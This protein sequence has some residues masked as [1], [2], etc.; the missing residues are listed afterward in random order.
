MT[1]IVPRQI[2]TAED[3]AAVL[4]RQGRGTVAIA[5]RISGRWTEDTVHLDDIGYVA[6]QLAGE[7][8]VYL[9]QNRF[10]GW[11]RAIACLAQLNALFTDLDYYNLAPGMSHL[12]PEHVLSVA[13][14]QLDESRI[15][16][17]T[18]AISTGRGIALIWMHSAVPRG[19]LG[20]WQA[21]QREIYHALSDL[22]AD[23]R[24]LDAARVLR[25]IGTE[26]SK[27]R[28]LVMPLTDVGHIWDFDALADEILPL[29]RAELGLLRAARARA[30]IGPH[31]R[32]PISLPS[33]F[34]FM[35]LA[36]G[37]LTD[38]QR[39]LQYRF[40]GVLPSGQRDEWMFCAAVN[41]AYLTRANILPREL[42]E[43]AREVAG[44]G[45]GE[46]RA[47]MS[48][49]QRRSEL[50]ALGQRISYRGTDVDP[51]Y[52]LR[53]E[54]IIERLR[55]TEGE[56]RGAKLHHL[57]N[58]DMQRERERNRGERRRRAAGAID[59]QTYEANS[60]SAHLPWEAEGITRRTWERRRKAQNTLTT[61]AVASPSG[62]MVVK[63]HPMEVLEPHDKEMC[64]TAVVGDP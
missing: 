8:D 14:E 54:T 13:L 41:M 58:L 6:H 48:A 28:T 30:W 12:R 32:R 20:R 49:V 26:N 63:P 22:G 51:R 18:I 50:A 29:K 19:A 53:N 15:P 25:L 4:H 60:L 45:E 46:T 5:R 9:S 1:L 31:L 44:W 52:R 39:L 2:I 27:S 24:A 57:V 56:M 59:R 38:L 10:F 61:R 55:I 11:R 40:M 21:C 43:L 33:E 47:R 7:T 17:P 42:A 37:R 62:C 23:A 36:E 34:N 35:T 16:A 3:H 64:R